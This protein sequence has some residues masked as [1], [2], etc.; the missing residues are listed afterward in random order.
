[1]ILDRQGLELSLLSPVIVIDDDE[2]FRMAIESVLCGRFGVDTV[3]LCASA[4]EALAQLAGETR[5]GLGIV[6][7]NMPGIDNRELLVAVRAAQPEVR[8]VVMSASRS[9]EDILMALSE[10]AQGYIHKG[11]GIGEMEV[12]LRQI[13]AGSVYVPPFTPQ[14]RPGLVVHEAAARHTS[15]SLSALTP[16]QTEVLRLL[17]AGQPNKS[18][19][20]QLEINL[21][22]VKFHLSVIFRVLGAS[23]RVE[24]AMLGA[25]V[26]GDRH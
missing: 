2:F 21:S 6:D 5:F 14:T 20:R 10:G 15:V 23:N 22:T 3:V 17:V 7:L 9:R 4:E 19:A 1:M 26:L 16:R 25:Q 18:I 11:L 13:A 24:A 8:V 12:A